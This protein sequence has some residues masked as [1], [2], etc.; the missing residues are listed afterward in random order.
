M[1]EKQPIAL[2]V[3]DIDNTIADK[4]D[5]WGT[6]L[7]SALN[8]LAKLHNRDRKDLEQDLLA[9]VPESMKHIS[10]PYIGK[11]LR[12]DVACTPSLKPS[13]P[14]MEKAQ[15]KIFH[16]WDKDKSKAELYGGVL[17][18]INKI[19]SSGAKFVLYTDSRESV[20]IPRLAK[21]GITADMI[22]GLYV[23]PDLKDGQ[24]VRKP[25]KGVANDLRTALGDKL[26]LL[27]PK[28]NKPNPKNMQRILDDMDIKDPKT[29]V[30]VGDNIRA[31]STGA[32]AVGMNFAWQKQGTVINDATLRCYKT[33]CQDPNYKL[34]TAEH[35]EQMD[36]TNR[37]TAVLNGFADLN[38]FYRFTAQKAKSSAF[39][40]A[41]LNKKA[42]VNR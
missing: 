31:D 17:A 4:F 5:A 6:A 39:L 35:L 33:F 16:E 10:G 8:K 7:D 14:E 29:A 22:D 2:V 19:K 13:S 40:T 3:S 15:E 1:S 11:D 23:Q 28:T 37:P 18:T 20:C 32:I 30:M 38:K 36:D 21:M 12:M 34:T 24:I 41:A 25:V 9:H 27:E 42:R 26:I